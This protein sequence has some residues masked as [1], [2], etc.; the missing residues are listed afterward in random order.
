MVT[1]VSDEDRAAEEKNGGVTTVTDLQGIS[2]AN[3]PRLL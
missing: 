3:P 1:G 2:T